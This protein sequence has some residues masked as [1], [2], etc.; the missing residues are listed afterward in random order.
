M[1]RFRFAFAVVASFFAPGLDGARADVEQAFIPEDLRITR[2]A[3]LLTAQDGLP[4]NDPDT[5]WIGHICDATY[6]AGGRMPAGGYGPY[7]V[8]RGPN[9]PSRLG[10]TI[11]DNGT[12]DFDRFQVGETDSLQGWWP[13]ARAFQSGVT[14]FP[15]YR[16]PWFG[17]DYGNTINYVIN[18][19]APKRTYGVTGLWHRDAG[20]LSLIHI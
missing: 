8:G 4:G 18:Q 6:T 12:W 9:R 15:D 14:A 16:Y 7:K 10:G 13:V 1:R 19:G 11:G 5:V 2:A 20:G 17:L 3:R